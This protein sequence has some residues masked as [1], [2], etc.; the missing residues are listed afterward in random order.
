MGI[1]GTVVMFV[2]IASAFI[3]KPC[4]TLLP[5][6]ALAELYVSALAFFVVW[7]TLIFIIFQFRK[8]MAKPELKV[9]FSEDGKT[10]ANLDV[11]KDKT[12]RKSL[13]L[14]VTNI[15]NAVTK[16]FQI[17][18]EVPNIFTP[19]HVDTIMPSKF[20]PTGNK[21]I[22]SFYNDGKICLFVNKP[23]KVP[24]FLLPLE[25]NADDYAKCPSKFNIIESFR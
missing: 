16:T 9:T 13:D 18:L 10:E 5:T 7:L 20:S 14:W 12:S 8:A 11:F 1:V 6:Y 23:V 2:L 24:D 15:G 17:D 22:Y 3:S 19:Q 4:A 21:R 25:L